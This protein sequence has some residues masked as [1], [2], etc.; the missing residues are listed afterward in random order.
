[1]H[2]LYNGPLPENEET[3]GTRRDDINVIRNSISQG[4]SDRPPALAAG[5]SDSR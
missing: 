3:D 2:Y 1:M 4:V 5:K